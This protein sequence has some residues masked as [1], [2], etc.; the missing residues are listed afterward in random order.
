MCVCAVCIFVAFYCD[1]G[2]S[3]PARS[4]HACAEEL[5]E[6]HG[7]I[8]GNA[9]AKLEQV[10]VRATFCCKPAKSTLL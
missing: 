7:E 3:Y 9:D 5:A 2:C 8:G 1:V 6:L 10:C 4:V